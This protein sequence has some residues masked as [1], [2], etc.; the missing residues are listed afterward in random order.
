ML[1]EM[2]RTRL[3]TFTSHRAK[4]RRPS[5]PTDSS[6]NRDSL[7]FRRAAARRLAHVAVEPYIDIRILASPEYVRCASRLKIV[8]LK[9][10]RRGG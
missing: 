1:C 7:V 8:S 10:R 2:L 5:I 6:A 9:R 3:A 4:R